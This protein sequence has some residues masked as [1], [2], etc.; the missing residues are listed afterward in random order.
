MRYAEQR[1]WTSFRMRKESR[2]AL[3][4]S[5]RTIDANKVSNREELLGSSAVREKQDLNEKVTYVC[6]SVIRV[7]HLNLPFSLDR[8][9]ALMEASNN[10]TEALQRTIALMQGEL[11]KSVLS[12]QLLGEC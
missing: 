5:K 2:G 6:I 4:A 11:E 3:L 7:L 8:E 1:D 9:D 10:V 12:T